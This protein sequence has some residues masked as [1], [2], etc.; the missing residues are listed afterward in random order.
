MPE[1]RPET[2]LLSGNVRVEDPEEDN[3]V[4]DL[5]YDYETVHLGRQGASR[6]VTFAGTP[7]AAVYREWIGGSSHNLGTLRGDKIAVCIPLVDTKSSWWGQ[8]LKRGSLPIARSG[9]SI[10]FTYHGG[11]QNLVLAVDRSVYE[12]V[13]AVDGAVPAAACESADASFRQQLLAC[14]P[15]RI[16][17]WSRRLQSVL[18]SALQPPAVQKTPAITGSGLQN[19]VLTALRS[20]LEDGRVDEVEQPLAEAVV[21][22]ALERVDAAVNGVPSVADLC[23][24]LNVSRRTL[25]LAFQRVTETSPLQFLTQRQ[26]NRSYCLLKRASP[27][28]TRVTDVAMACGFH[29]LGRFAGRYKQAFGE[30]PR[31]TLRTRVAGMSSKVFGVEAA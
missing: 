19:E 16:A 26:L 18:Q 11:H 27:E 8:P 31:E 7:A 4:F 17:A 9:Q 29:E 25:E 24:A 2:P 30:T 23:V 21:E 14:A 20:L 1:F 13:W 12:A 10:H 6:E 22:E 15:A 3:A 28:S 5:L